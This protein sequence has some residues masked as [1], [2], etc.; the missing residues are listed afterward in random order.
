MRSIPCWPSS[1]N[2][3]LSDKSLFFFN[4]LQ[5]R[6]FPTRDNARLTLE[7][8]QSSEISERA[9]QLLNRLVPRNI[10][11]NHSRQKKTHFLVSREDT[12]ILSCSSYPSLLQHSQSTSHLER[13]ELS[14]TQKLSRLKFRVSFSAELA[15]LSRA[16]ASSIAGR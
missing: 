8:A 2:E 4:R 5:Y 13:A 9:L 7:D 14:V 10:L 3:V 6:L 16:L 11:K 15:S 1:S 12:Y